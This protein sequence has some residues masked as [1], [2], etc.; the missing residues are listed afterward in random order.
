MSEE[1]YFILYERRRD[2]F[3][4]RWS[5]VMVMLCIV[6][7]DAIFGSQSIVSLCERE[8]SEVPHFVREC[9]V[10]VETRGLD[11]DGIYRIS[12]TSPS[13]Q[14]LRLLVDQSQSISFAEL[15]FYRG[16]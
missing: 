10:V 9:I 8:R 14:K 6:C 1:L 15:F 11:I 16:F 12:G 13:V 4:S 7:A 5:S 2:I 3:A